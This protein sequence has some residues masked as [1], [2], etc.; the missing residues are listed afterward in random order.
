MV[1]A[2]GFSLCSFLRQTYVATKSRLAEPE[3]LA[4]L[5]LKLI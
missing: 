1:K 3:S 4:D 2:R 5:E